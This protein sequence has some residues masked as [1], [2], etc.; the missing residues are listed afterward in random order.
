MI[1]LFPVPLMSRYIKI[2]DGEN[3]G[4][5][6]EAADCLK[7]AISPMARPIYVS[8]KKWMDLVHIPA[9]R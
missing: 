8:Y 9:E 1:R 3:S 6:S 4:M 5:L 7:A 2:E